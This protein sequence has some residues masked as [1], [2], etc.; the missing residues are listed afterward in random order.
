[1]G[2]RHSK[3][4]VHKVGPAGHI[5]PATSL[6][7]THNDYQAMRKIL[8]L[9]SYLLETEHRDYTVSRLVPESFQNCCCGPP[10]KVFMPHYSKNVMSTYR[11]T[12]DI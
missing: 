10:L 12:T 11:K 7:E 6:Q 3:T 9:Q 2:N 8:F 4:V 5:L 1:M